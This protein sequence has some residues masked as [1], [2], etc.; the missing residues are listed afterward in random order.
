[1][2]FVEDIFLLSHSLYLPV[3]AFF[4][5]GRVIR[6]LAQGAR[7]T[8]LLVRWYVGWFV[9]LVCTFSKSTH[10]EELHTWSLRRW[11]VA[12]NQKRDRGLR[13]S[14][15]RISD[16]LLALRCLVVQ[17]A[18]PTPPELSGFC[19]GDIKGPCIRGEAIHCL[20]NC[21]KRRH[22]KVRT[23]QILNIASCIHHFLDNRINRITFGLLYSFLPR[24][25]Y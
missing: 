21:W 2:V 3:S 12:A 16:W 22:N 18:P 5:K 20:H 11:R 8:F 14:C 13:Q 10:V 1:M 24:H 4:R 9:H 7:K 23:S 6:R 15:L 19:R 25:L 17:P